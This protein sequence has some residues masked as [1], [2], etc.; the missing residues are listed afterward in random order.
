MSLTA[1]WLILAVLLAAIVMS[2]GMVA[3]LMTDPIDETAQEPS[4]GAFITQTALAYILD[5][6]VVFIAKNTER[7]DSDGFHKRWWF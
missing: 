3:C 1:G 2:L 4:Y 6:G 7:G 5:A